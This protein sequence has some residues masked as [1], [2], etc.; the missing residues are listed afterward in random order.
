MA[1]DGEPLTERERAAVAYAELLALDHHAIDDD[2]VAAMREHFD[3]AQFLELSMMIGQ[4]IGF[5]RVLATL[6]LE[7]P[8]CPIG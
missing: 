4:Y 2:Q 8:V 7:T 3:E 1:G 5:G 6:A